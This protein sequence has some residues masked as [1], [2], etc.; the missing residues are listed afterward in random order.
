MVYYGDRHA[1]PQ[2]TTR[3]HGDDRCFAAVDLGEPGRLSRG[4]MAI[5]MLGQAIALVDTTIT[6]F[7]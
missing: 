7:V 1:F 5:T 4:T 2:E 3:D 6:N